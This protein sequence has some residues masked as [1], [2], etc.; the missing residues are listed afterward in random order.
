LLQTEL[1][2]ESDSGLKVLD[3]DADVV[4]SLDRHLPSIGEA[5]RDGPGRVF[6]ALGSNPAEDLA[7]KRWVP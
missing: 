1:G 5:E 7:S 2:K 3:D 4:Q 6:L